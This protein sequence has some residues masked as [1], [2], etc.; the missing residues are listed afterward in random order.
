MIENIYQNLAMRLEELQQS[1]PILKGMIVHGESQILNADEDDM[2][3]AA[4]A[5]DHLL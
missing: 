3:P 4:S 2:A 5:K 1:I